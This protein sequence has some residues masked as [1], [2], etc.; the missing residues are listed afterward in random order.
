MTDVS[1]CRAL[2]LAGNALHRCEHAAGS[3]S[4]RLLR[5]PPPCIRKTSLLYGYFRV[6]EG[7]VRSRTVSCNLETRCKH[8]AFWTREDGFYCEHAGASRASKTFH[9]LR[10][11]KGAPL[12]AIDNAPTTETALN[13]TWNTRNMYRDTVLVRRKVQA[14]DQEWMF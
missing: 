13:K 11:H 9:T 5:S 8:T 4:Q 7:V 2:F 1:K 14:A 6:N 10:K 3:A 12:Y